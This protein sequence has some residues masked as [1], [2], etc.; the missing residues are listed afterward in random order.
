MIVCAAYFT[1]EGEKT[2]KR[3]ETALVSA[4]QEQAGND[5]RFFFHWRE[6]GTSLHE[7]AGTAFRYH[8]PLLFIGAAG[9]AVRTIAPF[10][11]DKTT[12]SPVLVMD[13]RGQYVV[14][15]LSGHLG[16]A[17]DLAGLIAAAIGGKPVITTATDVHGCF[18]AD[19]FARR[20]GLAVRNR[21][22]IRLAANRALEGQKV[23]I[24]VD[25]EVKI[26]AADIPEDVEVS[27]E[28]NTPADIVVSRRKP[29]GFGDAGR[30]VEHTPLWLSPKEYVIGMGCRR[31]KTFEELNRFLLG[32]ILQAGLTEL[33]GV[34]NAPEEWIKEHVRAIATIDRKADEPG[35]QVLAQNWHIPLL[36]FTAEEL[37]SIPDGFHFTAS[38]FVR[39]VTGVSNVCERA[40]VMGA[41]GGTACYAGA[42]A[43]MKSSDRDYSR[44]LPAV[45]RKAGNGITLA[46]AEGM[47]FLW[48]F[49]TE[50]MGTDRDCGTGSSCPEPG[51][52]YDEQSS[53]QE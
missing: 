44:V 15:M 5:M 4:R 22:G 46:A 43:G 16:G 35:L 17:N 34:E 32:C 1:K 49:D 10:V 37:N 6:E 24:A 3:L 52:R 27:R 30:G 11:Y 39:E 50:V 19:V 8:L 42:C 12:D 7:F 36:T 38:D 23:R 26:L 53:G 31:G 25:P 41:A 18:A 45:R 28:E 20:N 2:G 13:D 21:E 14:P 40:A 9:I 47:P 29:E 33:S 51:N 48:T